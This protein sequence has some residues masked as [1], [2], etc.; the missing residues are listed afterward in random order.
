MGWQ[1]AAQVIEGRTGLPVL[2]VD[3][4]RGRRAGRASGPGAGR[5]RPP[6]RTALGSVPEP[7]YIATAADTY[8]DDP[9]IDRQWN[10]RRIYAP[11][12]WDLTMGSDTLVAVVDSGIDYSH[13]EFWKPPASG[14]GL[15]GVR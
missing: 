9:D 12:A 3:P 13:P 8:P 1:A 5:D 10:L 4:Y 7:N 6:L 14:P 11:A 15:R 2:A